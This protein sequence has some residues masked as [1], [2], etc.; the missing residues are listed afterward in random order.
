LV[1]LVDQFCWEETNELEC[2]EW[3]QV[4]RKFVED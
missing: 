4:G 1:D 2:L 3:V